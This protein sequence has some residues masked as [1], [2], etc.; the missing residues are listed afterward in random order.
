MLYTVQRNDS[1]ARIAAKLTGNSAN[2]IAL[3]AANRHKPM[4]TVGGQTTFRS[5]HVGEKLNVP[6]GWGAYGGGA[7]QGTRPVIPPPP[8]RPLPHGVGG[9]FGQGALFGVGFG[10]GQTT[11]SN[12]LQWAQSVA[13][14]NF[15]WGG[16]CPSGD[17]TVKSFQVAWNGDLTAGTDPNMAQATDSNGNVI[18][19]LSV[20]GDY[21]AETAAAVQAA[22]GGQSPT[23]C[24]S[25]SGGTPT[26]FSAAVI[27]A[28]QALDAYL[29]ANGCTNCSAVGQPPN[30][31]DPLSTLVSTFKQSILVTPSDWGSNNQAQTVTGSTINVSDPACQISFGS[32]TGG[33]LA[34]LKTVLGTAMTYTGTYCTNSSCSCTQAV[35]PPATTCTAPLQ[36]NGSGGCQCNG[37]A[38]TDPAL[39]TAAIALASYATPCDGTQAANTLIANFQGAWSNTSDTTM[40]ASALNSGVYDAATYAAVL[41]ASGQTPAA[42]CVNPPPP[43]PPTCTGG[44]VL[45]GNICQC[46]AGQSWN[47]SQCVQPPPQHQ[48]PPGQIM[49]GGQC[50]TPPAQASS[51]SG[52]G[53]LV[54]GVLILGIGGAATYY[55]VKGKHKHA[56]HAHARR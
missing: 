17:P 30:A 12:L 36:S 27:A 41:K 54:A 9:K 53:A 5:L 26:T 34:D 25:Y 55:A 47:G 49:Q 45:V 56:H 3:L 22:L 21:G 31:S 38:T 52:A 14:L 10:L 16:Q 48:C 11:D 19:Q 1:P 44:Q 8:P 39:C 29:Q 35:A 51:S 23:P 42:A 4:M 20:D 7:V 46:P 33:T 32:E 50:I 24:S 18:G 43:P 13:A 15:S 37:S 28:A 40:G 6:A 2:M